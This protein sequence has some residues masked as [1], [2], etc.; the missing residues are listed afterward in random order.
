MDGLHRKR[1][2]ELVGISHI[3]CEVHHGL[4]QQE[5]A[6]LFLIKNR[7]SNKP[8]AFDEYTVGLTANLPLFVDTNKVLQAHSLSVGSSSANM[9]GAVAGV[10]RITELYGPDVLDRTLSVAEAAWGRTKATWDGMLLGGLGKFLG[11]HGTIVNDRELAAKRRS[12]PMPRAGSAA[13]TLVRRPGRLT[14]RGRAGASRPATRSSWRCGTG[15]GARPTA[16]SSDPLSERPLLR[17]GPLCV[18]ASGG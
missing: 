16:S 3:T 12:S 11:I 13:S 7:E 9:I 2:F 6:I 8:S 5:E 17:E 15:A 14:P 4:S 18:G 1:V 10:L